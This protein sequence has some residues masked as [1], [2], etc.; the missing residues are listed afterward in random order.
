M[1]LLVG[2]H[3][4]RALRG[5][6]H[7]ILTLDG[8]TGR[9]PPDAAAALEHCRAFA[10]GGADALLQLAWEHFYAVLSQLGHELQDTKSLQ[11]EQVAPKLLQA[12]HLELAVPG[13]YHAS[14]EVC[15]GPPLYM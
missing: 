6:A 2:H 14:R 7:E 10:H 1:T 13:T 5:A 9:A 15:N 3:D 11:L 8:R 12:R 4:P